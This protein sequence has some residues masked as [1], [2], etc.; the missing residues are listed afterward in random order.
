MFRDTGNGAFLAAA[1][2][3]YNADPVLRDEEGNPLCTHCERNPVRDESEAVFAKYTSHGYRHE[4]LICFECE[5]GIL[6]EAYLDLC[7][8]LAIF[9]SVF[10]APVA[11]SAVAA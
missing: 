11:E 4:G 1:D 3:H 10:F 8:G 9:A 6:E 5:A 2:R 7:E